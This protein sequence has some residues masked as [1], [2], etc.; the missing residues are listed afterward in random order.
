MSLLLFLAGINAWGETATFSIDF[1]DSNKLNSTSGT[2]LTASN[3]S[4]FV[5]VV[6]G[7]T[8]T[9]VVTGVSVT[10][11]VQYGKN[12]GLTFG[13]STATA[14]SANKVTF[15]IGNDYKVTK[16]TVYA[17]AYE[18]GRIL[19]NG[20]AAGSG[21]LADKGTE[22]DNITSPYVWS[23]L[24]NLTSLEFS[25]DNG[26]GGN[27][28]RITIYK[29]VCEY[30]KLNKT[31]TSISFG[32]G[33]QSSYT[34]YSGETFTAPTASVIASGSAVASAT[35]SYTSSKPEVATVN[36]TT[37]AV[38]LVAPGTTEITAAYEGSNT[39]T[40][41]SAK[42]TLTVGAVYASLAAIVAAGKPTTAGAPVKVTL[43][44]EVIQSIY[45]TNAGYRNGIFL[46]SGEQQVEVYCQNVPAEWVKDGKVSGTI[47]G[48]WK[49]YSSTWEVVIS[50]WSQL[51]YTAPAVVKST[52]TITIGTYS[53]ALHV[54]DDEGY[55]VT[56]DGD[57]TVE[58]TSSK[59]D[60]AK[61][62]ISNGTVNISALKAG[63]TTITISAP[64]T[65]SYYAAEKK[66]TLTVT[67]VPL[68]YNPE[69]HTALVAEKDGKY[70]AAANKTKDKDN[71]FEVKE[72]QVINGKV[73][74]FEDPSMYAWKVTSTEENEATVENLEGYYLSLSTSTSASLSLSEVTLTVNDGAFY[75]SSDKESRAFS[76]NPSDPRMAS[77]KPSTTYSVAKSLPFATDMNYTRTV[78]SGK[79][80][81][82]CLPYAVES[83]AIT[84]ADFYNATINGD[85]VTLEAVTALEA[86]KP[87]IFL[88]TAN[89][90]SVEMSGTPAVVTTNGPLVGILSDTK[91]P[92][93]SYVL[94]T[95]NGVQKFYQVA[96]GQQP[97]LSANRAYLTEPTSG[98]KS[99]SIGTEEATAVNALNAITTN[100][101]KIY[102]INGR[103][104][105]T[106]QKGIN[107]V[108]GIKVVVK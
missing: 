37:G 36:A 8:A 61:A 6:T 77:Y 71:Y 38:T 63:T 57:A 94:Q 88:A 73:Y 74:G 97:K 59:E 9:N 1:Y 26:E 75:A 27:Q 49:L 68:T 11:T 64:E 3:Y 82:I 70:Y 67:K 83:N 51:T 98:A 22:I 86:G 62:T 28:K 12:G 102:D 93:G 47:S 29:I 7:L 84:G 99:L 106:L 60:V 85:Y 96:E 45:T 81:T 42:Y 53:T 92:I 55:L 4:P 24:N 50:D 16:C 30:E 14:A 65:D 48:T 89:S 76:Y 44:D 41:S 35:V 46:K 17:A 2:N 58:V 15:S 5:K 72:V 20:N 43:T 100:T 19:L 32:D 105:K 21:S 108:N 18:T 90:V 13:T 80:G 107:I 23:N 25:K 91:V 87:Y 66:Y 40:S 52:P 34:V 31:T 79:Y 69:I 54:G 78:T 95:Q 103:E 104:L 39:Y 101:A 33:A 10:G 56:Y